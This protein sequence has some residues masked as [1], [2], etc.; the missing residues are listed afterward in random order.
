MSTSTYTL[1]VLDADRA[2]DVANL[3]D[4]TIKRIEA[5]GWV[6]WHDR[7]SPE[8]WDKECVGVAMLSA[9]DNLFK[10]N[11]LRFTT[12]VGDAYR[13]VLS[14]ARLPYDDESNQIALWS[15][16]QRDQGTV[17]RKL[18]ETAEAVRQS[19]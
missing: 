10:G 6:D 5:V 7:K 9:A 17:L 14:Q 13:A 2:E 4:A 11:P 18:H 16:S 8:D 15:D 19:A 3:I 1:L 12:I